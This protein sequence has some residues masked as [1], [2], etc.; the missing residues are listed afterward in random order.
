MPD[1]IKQR[2]E[3]RPEDKW[4][5]ESLY[6]STLDWENDL[7]KT[8][9][10]ADAIEN[11]VG[12]LSESPQ[13]LLKAIE[14]ILSQ[15]R[16]LSKLFVYASMN[17]DVDLSNSDASTMYARVASRSTEI[18]TAHSFFSPELLGIP[19]DT[20]QK[21]LKT[22]FLA[23]YKRWLEDY[24]R[25]KPHTLSLSE[26]RLLAMS[27]E[28]ARGYSGSFGKLTNVDMPARLPEI[29]DAEGNTVQLTNGNFGVFLQDKNRTVRKD[30]FNNYYTE[31]AGN[32]NTL[33]SLLEG[34]IRTN[35]FYS[36][37]KN[38]PSAIHAS[39]FHDEVSTDV[40]DS[41]I[42]SVHKN[43]PILHE[44]YS[45]RKNL[46]SLEEMHLYDAYVPAVTE[47]KGKYSWEDAVELTLEAVKPLGHDYVNT[48][49]QGIES[50]WVDKYENIGKRGGAYSGGCHDSYPFILH[51][52][53]GT[54]RSVFTL[55]HEAG[56]SMHSYLSRQAQPYH[57]S[58]YRILVAE[59]A[60]I[61][62]EMLLIDLLLKRLSDPNEKAY[63]L[64]HLAGNFR[65]TLIRQT[66]FAEFEK[67]IYE[68]V[69]SGSSLTPDFLNAEYYALVTKYHGEI[70]D[71]DDD[72]KAIRFEWARIPHFY[73]NFYVYKYATGMAS[74]VDISSRILGGETDAVEKYLNFLKAGSTT[75]PL[76]TL[77]G[78]GV[79][80]TTPIPVDN[81][82][83]VMSE[84]VRQTSS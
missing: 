33:A 1:R 65:S 14:E 25:Y 42:D 32:I 48:L 66:M 60:S 8:E 28:I 79:D 11:Y 22:D 24:L 20:I 58:D 80:L 77:K 59:V 38:H 23:P 16:I 46:L 10:F 70:F 56:H 41:L 17:Q 26:E 9:S 49:K 37:A 84:I 40:Y 12:H 53:N 19:G 81:A 52:F 3:V 71:Y 15:D 7:A 36:K 64:D 55:A 62:N 76:E 13:V 74:A 4:D 51:N 61:T 45:I 39:L 67:L 29:T 82:L 68:E 72:D 69:E 31:V 54:L 30:A 47:S 27:G 78:A 34:Q 63:L 35:I 57:M 50:R 5:I 73:Y 6:P 2:S 21:W 43:L 75:S 18:G 83:K 44:Y